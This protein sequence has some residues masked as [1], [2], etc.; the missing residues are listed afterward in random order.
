M[1]KY[2]LVVVILSLVF[3]WCKRNDVAEIDINAIVD[4]STLQ[5]VITQVSEEMNEWKISMEQAQDL[6]NQLQQKYVDLT[7]INQKTIENQFGEIQKTFEEQEVDSYILPLRAKKLWMIEPKG[8][9]FNKT[10]S[11]PSSMDDSGYDSTTLVYKWNYTIALQQAKLIAQGA[12]LSVS[13]DF[14]KAQLLAKVGNVNYISGLDI[15]SLTK[16]IVY[17]NHELLETNIDYLLSVSVDPEGTLTIE[18][19]R[20]K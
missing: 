12:G 11:K 1:K 2:L 19:T 20:Y 7:D 17:V 5:G 6:V 13:K 14:E 8:M 16:W 9:E 15:A 4:L 18:T 10:L 3:L